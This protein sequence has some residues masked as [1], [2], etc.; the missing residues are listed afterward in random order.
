MLILPLH[1]PLT[2][3]T[4]P[5][6]TALLVALNVAI[7]LFLQS[8]DVSRLAALGAWYENSG[9]AQAEWPA[10]VDFEAMRDGPQARAVLQQLPDA[11][12]AAVLFQARIFDFALERALEQAA[13]DGAHAEAAG[14]TVA[15]QRDFQA[16]AARVVTLR[17]RLRYGEAAPLRW[18]TAAFLHGGV[19]HLVGNMFFLVAL[20]LL[21]EGALGSWRFVLLYLAGAA[22]ASLFSL[23]W[24]WGEAGGALGASG[25]NA[26]LMGAF[27]FIWGWRPVR[28]FWWFFVVFDYVK[29][30]AIW[31]FPIWA[32]WEALNML[33]NG[34]AGVGFDAHLGGLLTGALLGWGLVHGGQVRHDFLE[35]TDVAPDVAAELDG[36]RTTAGR[37]DLAAAQE[38]L[39]ALEARAPG[40]LD[41]AL[42]GHRLAVLG[43]Q[44]AEASRRALRALD[45]PALDASE[46]ALQLALLE[47]AFPLDRP[48]P[49][50]LWRERVRQRWLALGCLQESRRLLEAWLADGASAA[51]WFELALRARERGEGDLHHALLEEIVARFPAFPEAGKA[52]FMLEHG[53]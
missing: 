2:R 42:F 4:F 48:V 14:R 22:G 17:Y 40:R 12:R 24:N 15:L 51:N 36:I 19:M 3:A 26:A 49:D 5:V 13:L 34:G 53:H 9:L 31:L 21:V 25:A 16:R 33:F 37:M 38:Q 30:P 18:I 35:E 20:G 27:A 10:Y 47:E 7:F 44:R 8:G 41:V 52:R 39:E 28:F 29:K 50:G 1:R 23:A 6:V 32:G 43:L 11:E 46:V 45:I